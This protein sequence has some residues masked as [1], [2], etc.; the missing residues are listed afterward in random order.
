MERKDEEDRLTEK[1]AH[2]DKINYLNELN[3]DY[4]HE[5]EQ[6]LSSPAIAK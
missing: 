2:E 5:L 6:K 3:A 4:K 1:K